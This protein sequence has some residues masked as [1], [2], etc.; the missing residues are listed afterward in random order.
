M[1][2]MSMVV[3]RMAGIAAEY[4]RFPQKLLQLFLDDVHALA[5]LPKLPAV[6]RYRHGQNVGR[7]TEPRQIKLTPPGNEVRRIDKRNA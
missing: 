7:I 2:R 4:P 3:Y 5:P 1:Q 6:Y